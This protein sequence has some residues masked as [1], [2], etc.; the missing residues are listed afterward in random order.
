MW[1]EEDDRR[2]RGLVM[3]FS[4]IVR[5]RKHPENYKSPSP[6]LAAGPSPLTSAPPAPLSSS[7]PPHSANSRASSYSALAG[8][9]YRNC[10]RIGTCDGAGTYVMVV[11][12]KVTGAWVPHLKKRLRLLKEVREYGVERGTDLAAGGTPSFEAL[13]LIFV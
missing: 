10:G 5:V 4:T 11:A 12:W 8:S 2:S 7:P 3:P 1:L 13:F 6:L 9:L